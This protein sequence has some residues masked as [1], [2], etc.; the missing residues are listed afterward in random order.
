MSTAPARAMRNRWRRRSSAAALTAARRTHPI[1]AP[2]AAVVIAA[3]LVNAPDIAD[4]DVTVIAP[5]DA[6]GKHDQRQQAEGADPPAARHAV[7][8]GSCLVSVSDHSMTPKIAPLG[9]ANTASCP[10]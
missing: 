6:G 2:P 3:G 9:S 5:G 8:F 7:H 10:P 1:A 4:A